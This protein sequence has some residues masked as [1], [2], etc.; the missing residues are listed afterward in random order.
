MGRFLLLLMYLALTLYT[1]DIQDD[2]PFFNCEW[3]GNHT[4]GE[5][6]PD[7]GFVNW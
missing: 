1:A 4:C 6:T 2:H 7:H 5:G 3:H